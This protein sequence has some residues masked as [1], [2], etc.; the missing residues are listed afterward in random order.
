M[1]G[2]TTGH[3]LLLLGIGIMFFCVINVAMVLTNKIKPFSYFNL[4]PTQDI[5]LDLNNIVKQIPV[6]DKN[7]VSPGIT[8][9]KVNIIPF[10]TLNQILNISNHLLLMTFILGFG[11]RLASLGVQLARPINVKL[12]S[13][14][15][16]VADK[17]KQLPPPPPQ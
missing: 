1:K 2:K 12:D 13:G 10:E 16:E 14:S 6:G 9:P 3:I 5:S 4:N 8:L 17:N 7:I 15:P 11:F